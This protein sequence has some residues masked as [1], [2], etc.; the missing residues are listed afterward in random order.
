MPDT[1]P[2]QCIRRP[3]RFE[4]DRCF[5]CGRFLRHAIGNR[6][7]HFER[8]G[9]GA[10]L[11]AINREAARRSGPAP[12]RRH[13]RVEIEPDEPSSAVQRVRGLLTVC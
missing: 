2:C 3:I 9:Y 1:A 12:R 6:E 4:P 10:L 13:R 11:H 7:P 8:A 5:T